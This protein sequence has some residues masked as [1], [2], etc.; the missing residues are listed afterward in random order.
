MLDG[1]GDVSKI[2]E[3]RVEEEDGDPP[4]AYL[5]G[6]LLAYVAEQRRAGGDVGTGEGADDFFDF[7][8]IVYT[9]SAVAVPDEELVSTSS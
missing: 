2:V 4:A 8:S 9:D 7:A 3:R 6:S 1:F 5:L